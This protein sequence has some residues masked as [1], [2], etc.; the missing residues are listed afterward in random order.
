MTKSKEEKFKWKHTIIWTYFEEANGKCD[1]WE[2]REEEEK[3]QE[4]V[5]A[6]ERKKFWHIIHKFIIRKNIVKICCI[7][8]EPSFP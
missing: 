8:E 6:K 7:E 1:E 2:R 4:N 5:K 3:R